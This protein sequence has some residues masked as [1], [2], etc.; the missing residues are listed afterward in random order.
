MKIIFNTVLSSLLFF[1][2]NHVAYSQ[3]SDQ[4]A[5]AFGQIPDF[6]GIEI[7]PDG[8]RIATLMNYNG[9]KI[10][11]TKSLVDPNIAP[12]GVP[13]N[14]GEF[15]WV[16]WVNNDRLLAG[17]RY[18]T[19]IRGGV[20]L[21]ASQIGVTE[22]TA[23]RMISMD[24]D[25]ENQILLTR[26]NRSRA[27]QSVYQDK[28]VDMLP[29]D[30]E[31]VLYSLDTQLYL[32]PA[33]YKLN[34]FTNDR[35]FVHDEKQYITDWV[36]DH[37]HVIRLGYGSRDFPYERK[38]ISFVEYRKS[39]N[40]N[41]VTLYEYDRRD[42]EPPYEFL[43]FT[44]DP[45]Y[46]YVSQIAASGFKGIYKLHVDTQEISETI[47][48]SDEYDLRGIMLGQNGELEGYSYRKHTI[49]RVNFDDKGKK[50]NRIFE[51]NFPG[52]EFLI[53]SSSKDGNRVIVRTESSVD[54]GSYYLVDLNENKVELIDYNYKMID[55]EM[56]SEIQAVTYKASDGTD[57]HGY[58]TLP[59]SV[60]SDKKLP[61]VILPVWRQGNRFYKEFHYWAQYFAANGYA[62]LQVNYRGAGGYG[63]YYRNLGKGEMGRRIIQDVNEGTKW[64]IDNGYA[65]P[66]RIC[67]VGDTFGGYLALQAPISEPTLYN[68][69]VAHAPVTSLAKHLRERKKYTGYN[70]VKAN[71][72]NDEWDLDAASPLFNI[73]N[74]NAAV[75]LFHGERDMSIEVRQSRE[76]FQRMEDADNDIAYFEFEDADAYLSRQEH[77]VQFLK[78]TGRFLA[79]HLN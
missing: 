32:Y 71:I 36:T 30:P 16:R 58:L 73:E 50:I 26:R 70:F 64:M 34:V 79:K 76:Y 69:S 1:I 27:M 40:D 25:G 15:T 56:L 54:P 12:V 38:S 60:A 35:K 48:E 43:G 33:V 5:E 3:G 66:S 21:R 75:L 4:L 8:D 6:S 46:I 24:W 78:E 39:E 47:A 63:Q 51:Q 42:S 28:V 9:Q 41:W 65:D 2:T 22:F 37:N 74:M 59:K 77:R 55:P 52:A 62:V 19:K 13:F 31:H 10:L 61:T 7:S 18:A 68:C 14:E 49:K 72:T 29:D 11:M 45:D 23:T 17:V 53:S 67:L 44:E 20:A 57:I